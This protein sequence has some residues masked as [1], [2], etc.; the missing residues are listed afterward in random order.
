M[1]MGGPSQICLLIDNAGNIR[2]GATPPE[3]KLH[4]TG[5]MKAA[6]FIVGDVVFANGYMPVQ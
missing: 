4:V 2:I 5:S 3:Q 6:Q 1:V